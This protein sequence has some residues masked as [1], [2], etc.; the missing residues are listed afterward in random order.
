MMVQ[1]CAS[2][3]NQDIKSQL[4]LL[5]PEFL[6]PSLHLE[7]P[8]SLQDCMVKMLR[9]REEGL[10]FG[11]LIPESLKHQE[12][13]CDEEDE[14]ADTHIDLIINLDRARE[15]PLSYW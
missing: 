12:T 9:R 1:M 6:P 14:L 15:A 13:N 3:R 4:H 5:P 7:V 8:S 11:T 2:F 10:V